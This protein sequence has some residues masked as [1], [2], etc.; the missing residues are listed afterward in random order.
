MVGLHSTSNL[1]G[2]NPTSCPA[3]WDFGGYILSPAS[4][5]PSINWAD[6]T[7]LTGR[8]DWVPGRCLGNIPDVF[9]A[10]GWAL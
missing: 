2:S 5:L 10:V 3:D 7:C 8:P 6:D 4:A 1:V 9:P